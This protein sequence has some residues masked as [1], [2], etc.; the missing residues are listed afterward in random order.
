MQ[1]TSRTA[2]HFVVD[3]YSAPRGLRIAADIAK[4][5]DGPFNAGSFGSHV[6]FPI[7]EDREEADIARELL[8]E[9][10][11]SF[12]EARVDPVH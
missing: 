4:L 1:H 10:K 6:S 7:P 3:P 5:V 8:T 9:A 2:T 11:L 12:Y